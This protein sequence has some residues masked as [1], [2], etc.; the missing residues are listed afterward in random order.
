M[1]IIVCG[2]R[3]F[4]DRDLAFRALDWIDVHIEPIDFVIEGGQRTYDDTGLL[5]GGADW[6]GEEWALTRG[7]DYDTVPA[8]WRRWKNAAGPIRNEEM[9]RRWAPH[10]V[11][12][13]KGGPGTQDMI[14]RARLSRV[15]VIEVPKDLAIRSHLQVC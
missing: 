5:V 11:V 4:T 1:R 13:F 12:A 2:G 10:A 14:D 7:V 3:D 6:F 8:D 9:L 15:R